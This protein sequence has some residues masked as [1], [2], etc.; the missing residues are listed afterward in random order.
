MIIKARHICCSFIITLQSYYYLEKLL[1]K[2]LTYITIF[3]SKNIE[4]WNSIA[5][6]LLNLNKDDALKLYNYVYN[7]PYTHI[8]IDLVS[9]KYYKNFNLLEIEN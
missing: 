5:K 1:R 6:E 9:N 3:K 8:D 7:E 4:E 2:Q